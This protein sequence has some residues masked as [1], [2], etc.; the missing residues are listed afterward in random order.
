MGRVREIGVGRKDF[1]S[2]T[3]YQFSVAVSSDNIF[4]V[5]IITLFVITF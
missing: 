5:F 4:R 1:V 3:T 2:V